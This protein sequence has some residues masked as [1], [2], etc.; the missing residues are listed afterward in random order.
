MIPKSTINSRLLRLAIS[1]NCKA[2]MVGLRQLHPGLVANIPSALKQS[3]HVSRNLSNGTWLMISTT[4]VH[5]IDRCWLHLGLSEDFHFSIFKRYL[6]IQ[7]W[8][9]T[10]APVSSKDWSP[11]VN[12]NHICS[13]IPN[14]LYEHL[15]IEPCLTD[16]H[17]CERQTSIPSPP[18]EM[19]MSGLSIVQYKMLFL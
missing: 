5:S 3:L 15:Q 18:M 11:T 9:E 10:L 2:S 13:Q 6:D 8:I 12:Q 19:T 4:M 7:D 17:T 16:S 1:V 14:A